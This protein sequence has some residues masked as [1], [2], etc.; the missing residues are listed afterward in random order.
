MVLIMK[1]REILAIIFIFSLASLITPT[2][3]QENGMDGGNDVSG[4]NLLIGIVIGIVFFIVIY[5]SLRIL[6][7]RRARLTR[8]YVLLCDPIERLVLS[9]GRFVNIDRKIRFEVEETKD[10]VF[11]GVNTDAVTVLP[12]Y[13]EVDDLILDNKRGTGIKVMMCQIIGTTRRRDSAE[14]AIREWGKYAFPSTVWDT[15]FE[16][17]LDRVPPNVVLTI[18]LWK[19]EW[20]P[21]VHRRGMAAVRN[22]YGEVARMLATADREIEVTMD[23]MGRLIYTK[24]QSATEIVISMYYNVLKI[25]DSISEHR[26]LPWEVYGRIVHLPMDQL[27]YTGLQQAIRGGNLQ[28][29]AGGMVSAVRRTLDTLAQQFNLATMSEPTARMLLNKLGDVQDKLGNS[30]RREYEAQA[31]IR[32]L[33]SEV[34]KAKSQSSASMPTQA[35]SRNGN[36]QQPKNKERPVLQMYE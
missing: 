34:Y 26:V 11:W 7:V 1:R 22:I 10:K 21:M 12:A 15:S 28:E 23:G 3:A 2:M 6:D 36:S 14:K 16:L 19:R 25:W 29:V 27:N 8:P 13:G 18:P 9:A 33:V 17:D 35:P 30:L 31:N 24:I 20:G 5:I 4:I 32:D